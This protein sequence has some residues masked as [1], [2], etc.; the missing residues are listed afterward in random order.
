M[1]LATCKNVELSCFRISGQ[2]LNIFSFHSS[3]GSLGLRNPSTR[4]N[5]WSLSL[6]PGTCTGKLGSDYIHELPNCSKFHDS[7]KC[8][9]VWLVKR[10]STMESTVAVGNNVLALSPSFQEYRPCG[11][12]DIV[13][14]PVSC[15]CVPVCQ[16]CQNLIR[17]NL[18]NS[19]FCRVFTTC[20]YAGWVW[21]GMYFWHVRN[22][23]LMKS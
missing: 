22:F 16:V 2:H 9:A 11:F 18:Y 3:H 1:A 13:L 8:Y 12:F 17:Y 6:P 5:V 19:V 21:P 4:E 20:T 10:I 15:R 23:H 7:Q 14:F